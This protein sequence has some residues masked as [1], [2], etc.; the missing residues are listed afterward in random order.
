MAPSAPAYTCPWC[1]A[2]SDG[3]TGA[4][5]GC[6]APVDVRATA[7]QSG[8]YELPPIKDM[9]RIQCGRSTVQVEGLYV[10]VADFNLA[11]GDSVYFT[12]HLLLW[13][14]AATTVSTMSMRGGWKRMF[15]G[16]P[17][18]MTQAAGPGHVA[19]SKD[20]AGEMVALPLQP[21]QAVDVREHVFLV[22]TGSVAYDWF[23]T[24]VWFQTSS[25]NET[26]THYPL[27]MFMDRFVAQQTPGLLLLHASGNSFLRYLQPGETILVKPTALLFKD[28]TVQMHLHFEHPAGTWRSW[29]SWGERYVWLRLIGPGRVAIESA[30]E[31]M[32]DRPNNLRNTSNATRRQW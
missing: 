24:N 11:A 30:F 29:R 15:A 9:A 10:P 20:Q 14:D 7:S 4:C 1:R 25:G 17:L 18:I 21:G 5:P 8:W 32:E 3:S 12:H 2:V 31:H 6:G 27:G 26:E 23:Q 13:R 16:L 22:A 19:F 28:P